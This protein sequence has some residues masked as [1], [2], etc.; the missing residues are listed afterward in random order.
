MDQSTSHLSFF[1]VPTNA[2][3]WLYKTS[4]PTTNGDSEDFLSLFA[5]RIIVSNRVPFADIRR[6]VM[7]YWDRINLGHTMRSMFLI[8]VAYNLSIIV[9]LMFYISSDNAMSL[10]IYC[11]GKSQYI[12][13]RTVSNSIRY[14]FGIVSTQIRR[15]THGVI[16]VMF[17]CDIGSVHLLVRNYMRIPFIFG[18]FIAWFGVRMNAFHVVLSY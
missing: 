11:G 14:M 12:L 13:H 16:G 2:S 15:I 3:E 17:H 6:I 7:V 8:S 1:L 10:S 5:L 9:P 4:I 18:V